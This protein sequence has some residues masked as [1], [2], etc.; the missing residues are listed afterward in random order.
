MSGSKSKLPESYQ[1]FCNRIAPFKTIV[2]PALKLKVNDDSQFRL[3]IERF[4]KNPDL[5]NTSP[6]KPI[7]QISDLLNSNFIVGEAHS[8]VSPKKF[9]I[10]NMKNL[11]KSGFKTLFMEH[12]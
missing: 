10:E 3:N 8:H 11:K 12:L 9:L 4:F 2:I 5:K 7:T 1:D 6:P